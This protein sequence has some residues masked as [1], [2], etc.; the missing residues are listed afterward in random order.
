[1]V[2]LKRFLIYSTD[3]MTW[4]CSSTSKNTAQP[5]HL[6]SDDDKD[7]G[8]TVVAVNDGKKACKDRDHDIKSIVRIM[9][10]RMSRGT[11]TRHSYVQR[12]GYTTRMCDEWRSSI[13][14]DY[15]GS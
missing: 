3:T 13:Q 12:R 10:L 1:M 5:V 4:G 14:S 6:E 9:S 15:V 2:V 8:A 11:D 7:L